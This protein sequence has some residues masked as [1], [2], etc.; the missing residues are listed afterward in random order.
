[1]DSLVLS[2][3]EAKSSESKANNE[4]QGGGEQ[5]Q[6]GQGPIQSMAKH[7]QQLQIIT[8]FYLGKDNAKKDKIR[9]EKIK[10]LEEKERKQREEQEM[11]EE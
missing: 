4:N 2:H 7:L 1:M 10:N 5:G 3:I 11:L 9:L 8:S 6:D